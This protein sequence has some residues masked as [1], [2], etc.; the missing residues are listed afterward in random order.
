VLLALLPNLAACASTGLTEAGAKV[1]LMKA[2]PPAGCKEIGNVSGDY[3]GFP[4]EEGASKNV[5]RNHAAEQGA[6]YVRWDTAAANGIVSGTA[7]KC[8]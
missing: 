2:D 8:P 3:A 7:Y 1:R 4:V 6:N 5:M